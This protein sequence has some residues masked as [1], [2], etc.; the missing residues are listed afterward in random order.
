MSFKDTMKNFL[1]PILFFLLSIFTVSTI[2]WLSIQFL[3]TYCSYWTLA[4]PF[5]NLFS[6]GSPV[7]HFVNHVQMK[8][9][10]NYIFLW[11]CAATSCITYTGQLLLTDKKEETKEIKKVNYLG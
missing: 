9:A 1:K 7:C 5:M 4:G 2:Q 8:L 10:E 3:A 11:S 6:L